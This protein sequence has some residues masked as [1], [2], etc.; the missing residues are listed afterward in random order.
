MTLTRAFC[1]RIAAVRFETLGAE[2]VD[3]TVQAIKDGIAVALAGTAHEAPPR[4][5]A[6][7]VQSLGAKA[8]AS[9][10]G[11]GFKTSPVQAAYV[12]GV[13][14]HVL[15]F[16]PMWLPP[17]H[18]VSPTVPVAFA[19]AEALGAS[20]REIIAAVAKGMEAQGRIQ[21]AAN[22]YEPAAL[23]FH[24][25]G[26]VG[27]I[28]AA[29]TAAHLLGLDT[30]RLT[31]ALGIAASRSGSLLANVGSM[32]K[33]THCGY[34]GA[35]GLD[36]ALLAARGLTA[37]PDIL[38]APR[39]FAVTFYPDEFDADKLLA[40]GAPFR[41]VDPGH[42]IK[43]YPSQF[44]THWAITAALDLH[45]K[46]TEPSRI[47]R[48]T[49]R[50]PDM[51]YIDRPWPA[52]GLDGKFSFQYTAAAAL[53]DGVVG[54]ATFTD[55]RR[56]RADMEALL[57][58]TTFV[59]DASIKGEWS[60]LWVEIEVALV[61]GTTHRARSEG[62]LGAWGRPA[63]TAARHE[64]KLRDCLDAAL[65][66]RQVTRVLDALDGLETLDAKGVARLCRILAG[67]KP[68]SRRR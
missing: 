27:V 35:S 43:L 4:L 21:F 22:Q 47:T 39:G 23:R 8:V 3:R 9:V 24:P 25:P 30:G 57:A 68:G 5:L 67:R 37:N 2:C 7:H 20:G 18:A 41:V 16:E 28:G 62:P 26:I 1:E 63:L 48:L 12:N 14:T 10:W 66:P 29:V 13:S 11:C 58:K 44:A 32:T 52:T 15:D 31:H 65:A 60:K 53:L 61:D 36:A 40:F 38:A 59:R 34:A 19:L 64:V 54:I 51:A 17:T 56:S 6:A 33:S 46:I 50:G 49:I 45:G 55:E 42:A